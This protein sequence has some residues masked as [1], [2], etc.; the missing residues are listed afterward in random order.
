MT[1]GEIAQLTAT[2]ALITALVAAAAAIAASFLAEW[3][4]RHFGRQADEAR[5]EHEKDMRLRLRSEELAR[6]A[7]DVIE[8]LSETMGWTG[9]Y[10]RGDALVAAGKRTK[11]SWVPAPHREIAP[12]SAKL[13]RLAVEISNPQIARHLRQVADVAANAAN[14]NDWGGPHPAT[15]ANTIQTSSEERIGAFLRGEDIPVY[16]DLDSAREILQSFYDD[17]EANE[18]ERIALEE[19]EAQRRK[20]QLAAAAARALPP[21]QGAKAGWGPKQS[22]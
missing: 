18:N 2:V 3:L 10:A 14:I 6:E 5:W 13:R 15:L 22:K 4:A 12:I 7:Y 17:M 1:P 9:G 21:D 8:Q 20:D 11:R 16:T 19:A